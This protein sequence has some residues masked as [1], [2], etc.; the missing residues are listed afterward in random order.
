MPAP[1]IPE[2]SV[3]DFFTRLPERKYVNDTKRYPIV[4]PQVP[5]LDVSSRPRSPFPL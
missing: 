3:L 1:T 5:L 4:D 2:V